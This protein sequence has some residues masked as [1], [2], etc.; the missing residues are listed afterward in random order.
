MTDKKNIVNYNQEEDNKSFTNHSSSDGDDHKDN[1]LAKRMGKLM[2]DITVRVEGTY[3]FKKFNGTPEENPTKF[4]TQFEPYR[5]RWDEKETLA[6]IENNLEGR[7][8]SW[9]KWAKDEIF[10]SLEEFEEKFNNKFNKESK[11]ATGRLLQKVGEF[12]LKQGMIEQGLLE[13][14][15]LQKQTRIPLKDAVKAICNKI[16][17][18]I[19]R[20]LLSHKNAESMLEEAEAI[21]E[22]YRKKPWNNRQRPNN[23][24]DNPKEQQWV[25]AE[26]QGADVS[27]RKGEQKEHQ[28]APISKFEKPVPNYV[29]CNK[30]QGN[31]YANKCPEGGSLKIMATTKI[32]ERPTMEV[33]IQG[34]AYSILLD[35]GATANFMAEE[36]V[37]QIGFSIKPENKRVM[38]GRGEGHICGSTSVNISSEDGNNALTVEFLIVEGLSEGIIMGYPTMKDMKI[39]IDPSEDTIEV[40]NGETA[41]LIMV[42]H[43][44]HVMA[45]PTTDDGREDKQNNTHEECQAKFG[46]DEK[47]N[48]EI[49]MIIEK[50]EVLKAC[51]KNET[52]RIKHKIDLKDD[53]QPVYCRPYRRSLQ[54]N[55]L[56]TEEILKLI[57][58]GTIREST[59]A[60]ASPVVLVKKKDGSTRFCIDYRKLNDITIQRPFPIPHMEEALESVSG[61]K[62]FS[63]LDLESGYHQIEIWEPDKEKTAFITRDGLYEWNRMP[64]GLINAPYTFQRI[65]NH[66]FKELLWKNV[67]VYMDDILIF[68]RNEQ[69]HIRDLKSV[70][71]KIAEYGFKIKESKCMFG[72]KEIDFLGFTIK[73]SCMFIK[74]EQRNKVMMLQE[75]RN[76]S[77]LRSTLG[78]AAFFKRF[79]PNYSEKINPLLQRLKKGNFSFGEEERKC[80]QAL[81]KEIREAKSLVLPDLRGSFNL[82]ADASGIAI[83]AALSQIVDGEER[84]VLWIS[85]KLNDAEINYTTTE[86]ECLAII[87][88]VERLKIYLANEFTIR[89]D[90]SALTWLVSQ[91]E[92]KERIARWIMKLQGYK[93]KIEH[94]PGRENIIADAL[95]RGVVKWTNPLDT[96]LNTMKDVEE[97]KSEDQVKEERNLQIAQAHEEVGHGGRETTYGYLKS[98]GAK[99]KNMWAEMKEFIKQCK[100]CCK[101]R[102]RRKSEPK[103]RM[104]LKEPFFRIG[105]DLVGP[106]PKTENGNRFLI[107]ATDHLTRWA[108]VRAVKK[109]TAFEVGLFIYEEIILRHG[110]PCVILSDQGK[111]FNS[112]CIQKICQMVRSVKSFTSAYNPQCNGAVERLNRTLIAKLAKICDGRWEQWDEYVG[113]ATY[114][115]RVA[116]I[117]RLSKSPFELL[118]GRTPNSI[119]EVDV[120]LKSKHG[121][122]QQ[123]DEEMLLRQIDQ[124]RKAAQADARARREEEILK[125]EKDENLTEKLKVGDIVMKQRES[126]ERINKLDEKWAGPYIIRKCFDHGGFEI[127]DMNGKKFRYNARKLQKM[128]GTD[129]QTWE[130]LKSGGVLQ[131]DP[132]QTMILMTSY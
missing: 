46:K 74:E 10:K 53:A 9:Y 48:S 131:G 81:Q 113:A 99:W 65:M 33:Q 76:V 15:Q 45:L 79:I 87:W 6:H 105:I 132:Q 40:F 112:S 130:S 22:E 90:H 19:T 36:L 31:H 116:P 35:T 27:S 95:S 11:S 55:E 50:T 101:Y 121:E 43:K 32:P 84:P 4:M 41:K 21:D 69:D 73:D 23:G 102:D 70:L 20:R 68:S 97:I 60:F 51:R 2:K 66:V 26:K 3:S 57:K 42:N 89:T 7:A 37:G 72:V 129:P 118:Y 83:G 92:P 85:R 125:L 103:M 14:L 1:E 17:D 111:E 86:K 106:L 38:L 123:N 122:R 29:K 119:S 34:R 124:Y 5:V 49:K 56:I 13:I 16:P 109:K 80:L 59:S 117:G 71:T 126:F 78:F 107:V 93:F 67:V 128:E 52:L 28:S 77:D 62:I 64:F 12:Q 24:V 120:V 54:Q 82:Y 127:E 96:N 61:A 30:C 94:I 108:E 110:A 104:E 47:L 18:D 88:A 25:T 98:K 91:K 58:E 63:A 114:C 8:L 115:Y 39:K 44:L 100:I 75:P